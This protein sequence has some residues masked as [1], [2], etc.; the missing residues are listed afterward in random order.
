MCGT[1]P[2]I[3]QVSRPI[4]IPIIIDAFLLLNIQIRM[5]SSGYVNVFEWNREW[6]FSR[7]VK[8]DS[9]FNVM[10]VWSF[11]TWTQNRLTLHRHPEMSHEVVEETLLILQ[12]SQYYY[13]LELIGR[14]RIK[15]D[16][17]SSWSPPRVLIRPSAIGK[18]NSPSLGNITSFALSLFE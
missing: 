1:C 4:D 15:V 17:L 12:E 8:F 14:G 2:R 9:G 7:R 6:F 18:I 16:V 5:S 3:W 10:A 11:P 13:L